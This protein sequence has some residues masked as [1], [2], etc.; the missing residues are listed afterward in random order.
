MRSAVILAAL[1]VSVL[2][3]PVAAQPMSS[4]QA[5]PMSAPPAAASPAQAA[6]AAQA[7]AST[8]QSDSGAKQ[9]CK[10]F[11][12]AGT[13]FSKKE[14]HTKAEWDQMSADARQ[15]LTDSSS[16]GGAGPH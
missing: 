3:L 6:Q 16:R 15:S 11:T 9:V 12:P 7:P 14:C 5:P 10:T 8:A 1:G 2:A 13:R 4:S